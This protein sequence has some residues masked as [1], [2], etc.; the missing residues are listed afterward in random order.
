MIREKSIWHFSFQ[1]AGHK[2]SAGRCILSLVLLLVA[3][4]RFHEADKVARELGNNCAL[5]QNLA[6]EQ[7]IAGADKHDNHQVN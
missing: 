5:E 4:K 6:I 1:E 7:L 2:P 3:L